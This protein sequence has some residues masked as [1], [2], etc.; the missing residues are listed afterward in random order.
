MVNKF[1][2]S[3]P[4]VGGV[5]SGFRG[6][7]IRDECVSNSRVSSC[8]WTLFIYVLTFTK[9]YGTFSSRSTVP[10]PP[11]WSSRFKQPRVSFVGLSTR[12]NPSAPPPLRLRPPPSS[13]R[14]SSSV[15]TFR[16]SN[17]VVRLGF[18]STHPSL[19]RFALLSRSRS[20]VSLN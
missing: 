1:S 3:L 16:V 5:R 7:W 15:W 11:P 10:P 14:P 6:S 13:T 18:G 20:R 17:P 12:R 9:I 19:S 2:R 8:T 4:S